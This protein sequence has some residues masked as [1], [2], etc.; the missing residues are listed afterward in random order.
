MEQMDQNEVSLFDV[1]PETG[2]II[3]SPAEGEEIDQDDILESEVLEED[4]G[5]AAAPPDEVGDMLLDP[6]NVPENV[7]ETETEASNV[8]LLDSGDAGVAVVLEENVTAAILA[9]TPAG[10]SIG[11][12][13][14]DYFDRVV[15]GLPSDAAYIAYRTNTDDSYDAVLY[16]GDDYRISDNVIIFENAVELEVDRVSS[17]GYNNETN[18]YFTE[19]S[20]VSLTFS[21]AGP[22]IYYTNAVVG[23]PVL[24][25][26]EVQK[27]YGFYLV[28]ALIGALVAVIMAKLLFRR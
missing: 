17:S 15:S 1:D 11:S 12:S 2:E 22:V 9:A 18:Y 26:Y 23:Y 19:V 28:P 10:G 13:T 14:L 20:D 3:Y 24:G 16:Y 7:V 27:G 5:D 21:Q 8:G 25:G 4:A 6:E